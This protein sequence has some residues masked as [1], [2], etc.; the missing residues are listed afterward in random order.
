MAGF[1]LGSV[2][3]GVAEQCFSAHGHGV[4]DAGDVV[5]A[6]QTEDHSPGRQTAEEVRHAAVAFGGHFA[7]WNKLV[8]SMR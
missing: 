7:T 5:A 4:G 3:D 6:F 8:V 2:R 1:V